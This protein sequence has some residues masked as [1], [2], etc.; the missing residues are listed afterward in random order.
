MLSEHETP[1]PLAYGVFASWH[2]PVNAPH[3]KSERRLMLKHLL[4]AI[5]ALFCLAAT[6]ADAQG[7]FGSYSREY[8]N[9][10]TTFTYEVNGAPPNVCGDIH[11][12]RRYP[13]GEW[14]WVVSA[15]WICTDASGHAVKGPWTCSQDQS[16]NYT[17]ISWP[18]GSNATGVY[19]APNHYCQ[20][21]A[22]FMIQTGDYG[23][24]PVSVH[25][26]MGSDPAPGFDFSFNGWSTLSATYQNYDT[27][28]Y[29]SP[30]SNCFCSSTPVMLFGTTAPT[31]GNDVNWSVAAPPL[32][33]HTSGQYTYRVRANDAQGDVT[34]MGAYTVVVH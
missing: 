24:P 30:I 19:P 23:T 13:P 31:V 11:T 22:P 28:L 27:Q 4:C 6:K 1:G 32:T 34:G 26:Y 17:Y 20:L 3:L 25:G 2:L 7:G 12:L 15:T 9:S 14:A 16:D 18:D 10:H 8:N 33:A 5:T 21:S 29:Y